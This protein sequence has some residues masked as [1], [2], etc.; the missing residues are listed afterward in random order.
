[1]KETSK[2]HDMFTLLIIV[3]VAMSG[4]MGI[5]IHL[6]S[7]PS[8]MTYMDTDKIHIQQSITLYLLGLGVSLLFYGPLSDK[9]GRKPIVIFGLIVACVSSFLVVL[10]HGI[11]AFLILRL[12]QGVGA[13]A[14]AGL[15]R[16][17]AVDMFHKKTLNS[18]RSYFSAIIALSPLIAPLLGGY[19]QHYFGWQSNFIF[20]SAFFLLLIFP[21]AF[22]T[23]ETNRH[24]RPDLNLSKTLVSNYRY[25]LK[26]PAFVGAT[27]L[28]GIGMAITIIYATLTPFI[29]LDVYHL[30]P[31]VYG[32]I[33]MGVSLGILLGRLFNG[34]LVR[35]LNNLGVLLF[36]MHL[37][38]IPGVFIVLIV[39]FHQTWMLIVL[40]CIFLALS[41]QAFMRANAMFIA[42]FPHND[43]R[44]SA[45]ALFGSFQTL[46]SF[47]CGAL[48]SLFPHEGM[49][50]LGAS[51]I[52]LGFLSYSIYLGLLKHNYQ[53]SQ[54]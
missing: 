33:T 35:R 5:D 20:L 39:L 4:L 22:L 40:L 29:F 6:A 49:L 46:V 10:F 31:I 30:S 28:G 41:G 34:F 12:I 15:G 7:M 19:L 17:M 47:L 37:I 9:Y 52:L 24:I 21:Y 32:W 23:I 18:M 14:S 44:G 43:K 53:E 51:Y 11:F 8:M 16:T 42:L 3:L 50:L 54:I 1:M 13:G 26:H 27:L 36:G 2:A 45:G 38:V 25:L 48:I